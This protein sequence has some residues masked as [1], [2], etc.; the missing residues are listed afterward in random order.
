MK[1]NGTREATEKRWISRSGVE[2]GLEDR[3]IGLGTISGH[4]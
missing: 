2:I 1:N 3:E 4:E